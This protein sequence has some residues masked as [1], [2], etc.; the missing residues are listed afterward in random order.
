[1]LKRMSFKTKVLLG[2]GVM[3]V[4]MLGMALFSFINNFNNE[5][6]LL[7]I[8]NKILPVALIASDMATDIVQVQQFLTD[9]SA[10]R[11]RASYAEAEAYA[12]AFKQGLAKLRQEAE[13][14]T[15]ELNKLAEL[16]RDF[17]RFYASGKRMAETYLASGT[18]AG[19]QIMAEF[20]K[21]SIDLST[22]MEALRASE[23]RRATAYVHDLAQSSKTFIVLLIGLTLISVAVGFAIAYYL[24]YYLKKQLGVDPIFAKGIAKEI[25]KGDFNRDIRL[26]PGDTKSLLFALKNMQQQ[27]RE[28][29]ENEQAGQ[30]Q[31]RERMELDARAKESALR[32]QLAL[33]KATA[34]LMVTD[35]NYNIIYLNEALSQ[36]FEC[37]AI[38]IRHE[39]PDFDPDR[40]LGANIDLFQ[41]DP[42]PQ[43][44]L[45][46]SLKSAVKF[47]LTIG[48]KHF[49]IIANPAIYGSGHRIGT[50][51][52]WQ[53]RTD[54]VKIE[55][56]IKTIVE[57]VKSGKLNNRLSTADKTGFLQ[58]LSININDLSAIIENVFND[59]ASVMRSMAAGN[60]SQRITND[61]EGIYDSCK[62]SI[63]STLDELRERIEREAKAKEN[64]LRIQLA[65]DKTSTNV[66]VA[67]ENHHII[68]INEALTAF[69]R[70]AQ[71]EIRRQ[72][73]QF[74]LSTLIGSSIDLFHD[75]PAHQRSYLDSM[76]TTFKSS[77]LL[78]GRNINFIA[79]PVLDENGRRVGTVAE[80]KDRTFEIKIE[81]EI[82]AIVDAVK[83]GDLNRRLNLSDKAGFFQML[84]TNINE[85]AAVIESVF[86]DIAKVIRGMAV[87]DLTQRI[88]HDYDGVYG[89][90]KN[91]INKSLDKLQDVFSQI[92]EAARSIDQSS[93]DIAS[94]NNDLSR[95]AEQQAASLEETASSMEELTSTVKNNA[96]YAKQANQEAAYARELAELGSHVAD[97]AIGAMV[98]INES[99]TRIG[100][101]ISMIDEIALQTN[102]LALN[103]AVEAARAG[104][105][106]RGFAV[107]ASEVR[108]LA[109]R[110]AAAAKEIKDLISDTL[111]KVEGGSKL[112]SEAGKSLD[113]IVINVKHLNDIIAKIASES[114]DQ[115]QGIKQINL[116][117]AQMDD[118][119][120]QNA[121]LAEKTA[122]ASVSMH[123]QS[124]HMRQLMAFFRLAQAANGD[125][126][127]EQENTALLPQPKLKTLLKQTFLP[128]KARDGWEEF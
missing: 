107:V 22:R 68:Y 64:A 55:Q 35:E 38:D 71:N 76:R 101:I 81:D 36:L 57:A 108:N 99:N 123:G 12:R 114:D 20:D 10:T 58:L 67:D 96:D 111:E 70:E 104:E 21:S 32:I 26:E 87:G 65:L 127:A 79:N 80:W 93:Y 54:E 103:A 60:L 92:Q 94:G 124:E 37:A 18:E 28:R 75:D 45:L 117:I 17:D 62:R 74:D 121:T 95:R 34:N 8:D 122:A 72:L 56:E 50:V 84:G 113:A 88:T 51:L 69:F 40:L 9:V 6:N 116:A 100:D 97:S 27:L 44:A 30:R 105:Q 33:D 115:F 73:P 3:L 1:M 91:D 13:G 5:Q 25:A 85:L 46:D 118:I 106:G 77:F 15:G 125:A 89:D 82:K 41:K 86:N 120:Q 11:N 39:S 7:D 109:Q 24:N 61:Y 23:V 59:I 112:V 43:R 48:G 119:T 90:C 42:L 4:L 31:L 66:M 128:A 2:F 29:M 83:N 63:N 102:I 19:N 47:N 16:E 126:L 53:D 98:Q 78:G 49:D 110:S 14:D 52:E